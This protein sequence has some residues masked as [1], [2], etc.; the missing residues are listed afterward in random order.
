MTHLQT[1]SSHHVLGWLHLSLI[2]RSGFT[3]VWHSM[4]SKQLW[5]DA[6]LFSSPFHKTLAGFKQIHVVMTKLSFSN[7]M[8]SYFKI[9]ELVDHL[10]TLWFN[11]FLTWRGVL[12]T[13][14]LQRISFRLPSTSRAVA[15]T[16]YL[17]LCLPISRLPWPLSLSL[18]LSLPL[19]LFFPFILSLSPVS[20]SVSLI[21][22]FSSLFLA[23][24]LFFISLSL[25]SLF[26]LSLTFSFFL[27]LSAPAH[28]P[29]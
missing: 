28:S 24:F 23:Y 14:A 9:W 1:L 20:P 15:A 22:V 8:A 7:N 3:L 12:T 16:V 13:R 17:H 26:P 6:S 10:P 29:C 19:V 25:S 5:F 2:W 11:I 27:F 21:S 4:I 18:S